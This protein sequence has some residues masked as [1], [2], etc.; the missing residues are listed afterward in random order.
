MAK[1]PKEES[2]QATIDGLQGLLTQADLDAAR[3]LEQAGIKATENETARRLQRLLLE[4]LHHRVKNTLAT[5]IAITSQSLRNAESLDQG[6]HAVESRLLALGRAHDL[7]MKASWAH[8]Q[9]A[10]VI[11]AAI[12]P[13]D[14]EL[15]SRFVVQKTDLEIGS[16][17]VLPLTMSFNELCT[18]AVKYGALSVDAG[19]VS[20][21]I[22]TD[23]VT[24]RLKLT[25]LES[26]GPPVREPARHSFGTRLINRLAAQLHGHASLRYEPAGVVYELDVP[27]TS[28]DAKLQ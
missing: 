25:W 8:A 23:D 16:A 10:D 13:F 1:S 22:A 4:E 7:L 18:N 5:V 19:R 11:H 17:V 24:R 14:D 3:L 20:I 9:L 2:L 27:L 6:R 28:L 15:V 26:G 12:A 21:A